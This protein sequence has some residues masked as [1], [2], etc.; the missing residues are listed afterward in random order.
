M[1]KMLWVMAL[2]FA[3]SG[4]GKQ[5][6]QVFET[7]GNV[8]CENPE[9]PAASVISLDLPDEAAAQAM[10][11]ENGAQVYRWDNY[12]LR[13]QTRP[14]GDIVST[15]QEL[16]GMKA[17]ALTI[18]KQDKD[19][20]TF[21]QTVWSA[22]GDEGITCGRAMVADDGNYHYC[23][24]LTNPENVNAQELY[25]KMVNSFQIIPANVGK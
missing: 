6:Q 4:C 12:E 2:L 7:V 19:E 21:Y 10:S 20:M 25:A 14:S 23:V 13:T 11:E 3:L 24:S 16:T 22:V 18:M 8:N 15:M 5:D 1:K 9:R 17:D